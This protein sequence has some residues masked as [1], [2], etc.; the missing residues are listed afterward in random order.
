MKIENVSLLISD[1]N[2]RLKKLYSKKLSQRRKAFL[3]K[4]AI[5]CKNRVISKRMARCALFDGSKCDDERANDCG[6]FECRNNRA[7][8]DRDFLEIVGNPLACSKAYPKIATLLW[9][10]HRAS[11]YGI[12]EMSEDVDNE[13]K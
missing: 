2:D 9:I 5:N 6:Y 12:V 11:E 4:K 10:L 13:T 8:V 1:I 7:Q 3:S